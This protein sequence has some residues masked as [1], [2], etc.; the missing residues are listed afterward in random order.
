MSTPTLERRAKRVA[1]AVVMLLVPA[2][3]VFLM[4]DG[5][6]EKLLSAPPVATSE[7]TSREGEAR[8]LVAPRQ[9]G[10]SSVSIKET[11]EE[12]AA[13]KAAAARRAEPTPQA[14]VKPVA[15]PTDH[16]QVRQP[17]KPVPIYGRDKN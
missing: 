14:P 3:L 7:R 6:M 5:L 13:A 9:D 16:I 11:P 1:T 15:E 10:W 4:R 2:A 8:S 17:T 12:A